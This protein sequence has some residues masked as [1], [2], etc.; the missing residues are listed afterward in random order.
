M[1]LVGR[2]SLDSELTR[3]D[4]MSSVDTDMMVMVSSSKEDEVN[5]LTDLLLAKYVD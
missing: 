1:C 2:G 5:F 3:I 4:M